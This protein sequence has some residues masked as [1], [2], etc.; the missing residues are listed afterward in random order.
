M[1]MKVVILIIL[2]IVLF[3]LKKDKIENFSQR[4]TNIDF[5][6]KNV[7]ICMKTLYRKKLLKRHL[8]FI[9]NL[10]PEVK[11]IVADDSDEK[12]IE[13]TKEYIKEFMD[14]NLE[15]VEL[16]FDSGISKGRNEC[17]KRVKTPFIVLT[18]DSRAINT[19]NNLIKDII[20]FL[21]T[22]EY[23]LVTGFCPQRNG[24]FRSFIK[25]FYYDKNNEI[26]NKKVDKS[27][28]IKHKN[29]N[30]LKVARGN[31][32]FI[33]K[34]EILKKHGWNEKFKIGEHRTF[35]KDLFKNNIKIL[36]CEKL[37][38]K[39]FSGKLRRYEKTGNKMRSRA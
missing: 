4:A 36:Y 10:Y 16:P 21:K 2:L 32:T 18:D 17:V 6:N 38:F 12:Y 31:N 28:P 24:P 11:I 19:N 37:I 35:F 25:D 27:N 34:T 3:C 8:E 13:K 7:T 26:K 29:L 14:N 1:L 39:Q 20:S 33:A 9:R 23:G 22:T 15:Y 30:F 5:I